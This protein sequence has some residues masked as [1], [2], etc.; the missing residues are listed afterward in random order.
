[1]E[2]NLVINYGRVG[3]TSI[4]EA[5][6]QADC[7]P[8]LHLHKANPG[9]IGAELLRCLR[10]GMHVPQ[11]LLW[12]AALDGFKR[13]N[14]LLNIICPI[15]EPFA[16]DISST[17]YGRQDVDSYMADDTFLHDFFSR[18]MAFGT[19]WLLSHL[20]PFSGIDLFSRPFD[21]EAGYAIYS[22][23]NIRLLLVQTEL[24]DEAKGLALHDLLKTPSP[25]LVR[26]KVNTSGYSEAI[27]AGLGARMRAWSPAGIKV[28]KR[29]ATFFY[30][31]ADIERS[32]ARYGVE[33]GQLV[34]PASF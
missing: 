23:K 7:G 19:D 10:D 4:T 21:K 20:M 13:S 6:N 3:S 25:P 18:D 1:M 22:K 32:V 31:R 26:N 24:S 34:L 2:L 12:A 33:I 8:V 30:T 9:I 29:L 17:T 16:R 28:D 27:S 14:T 15:R 11:D 5:L